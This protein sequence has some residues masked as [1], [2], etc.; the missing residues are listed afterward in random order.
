MTT[1]A[2]AKRICRPLLAR[3]PDLALIG[4]LIA[5][6]PFHHILRG[7]YID[8][9]WEKKLFRPTWVATFLFERDATIGFNW[10]QQIYRPTKG[11]WDFT[12]PNTPQ[13][14]QEEIERLALPLLR[15]VQTIDNFV[16]FTN[17]DRFPHTH[18]DLYPYRKVLFD[19]ARGDFDT[20]QSICELLAARRSG[21]KW[22]L[23]AEEYD[24]VINE[25]W[26]LIKKNDRAALAEILH[27]WEAQAVKR[28]KLGEIW[29]PTPFPLEL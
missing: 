29:E 13:M 11:L 15:P 5:I 14:L 1:A 7:V 6:K 28:K 26:P 19:I 17:K 25:L 12:D 20:A 21:G 23:W 10:G 18:L 22:Q 4:R 24:F 3:N 27:R 8:R 9:T 2:E 16:T